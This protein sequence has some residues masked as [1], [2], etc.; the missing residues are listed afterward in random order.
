MKLHLACFLTLLATAIAAQAGEWNQ[1]RGPHRTGVA[2]AHDLP[3]KFGEGKN[4]AWHITLPSWSGSSPVVTKDHVFVISP[5]AEEIIEETTTGELH[6]RFKRQRA[7]MSGD[8]SGGKIAGP[9][10]QD[11]LL[12]CVSRANGSILWQRKMDTGNKF[13]LKQNSSTPSPVTDGEHVWTVTANGIVNS[14]DMNGETAWTLDLQEKYG[15]L[16]VGFGYATSPLL[17]DGKLIFQ[18]IHGWRGEDPSYMLAIDASTGTH[19]WQVERP[20]DAENECKDAYSTPTIVTH[21]GESQV[22]AV[23]ADYATGHSVDT[24]EEIWRLGGL[25]PNNKGD[26]R[27]ISS[28]LAIDGMIY[29]PT[30]EKP[31]IAFHAGGK[32]DITESH[33]AWKWNEKGSPDVP[34][35]LCD[36]TYFYM[37]DDAGTATCLNAK[38]GELIWGPED[39]EIGR[40]TGS[41]VLADGKIYI[42]SESAEVAVLTAGAKYEKLSVNKLDG[43]YTLSTPAIDNT[44][45][46]FRSA[47]HLICVSQM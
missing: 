23:G 15:K 44:Q 28:P 34:T 13:N 41:P 33:L 47:E 29:A 31:L 38:T 20:S 17:Y 7:N 45:L 37:V 27:I 24:G 30:R 5:S 42:I 22:V 14:Y 10:G 3:V 19:I 35:A 39:L 16:A 4:I 32:G 40:V 26:Y 12:F 11:L 1:W 8:R 43:G 25:N 21:N 6:P 9:G 18:V 46:F 2:D 36:G